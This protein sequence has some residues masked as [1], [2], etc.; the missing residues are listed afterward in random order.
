M[1]QLEKKFQLKFV[2]NVYFLKLKNIYMVTSRIL[3]ACGQMSNIA[4]CQKIPAWWWVLPNLF[5]ILNSSFVALSSLY[6]L[7]EIFTH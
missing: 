2:V 4:V 5:S 6:F 3:S 7:T 1:H